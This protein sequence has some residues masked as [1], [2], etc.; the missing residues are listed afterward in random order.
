MTTY[1]SKTILDLIYAATEQNPSPEEYEEFDRAK[2]ASVRKAASA[3]EVAFAEA[4]AAEVEK[5][6][7]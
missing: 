7:S 6:L 5:R 4:V 3:M 2:D 1:I